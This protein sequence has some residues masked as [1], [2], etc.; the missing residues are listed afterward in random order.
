MREAV[1]GAVGAA[2]EES[3]E[4]DIALNCCK[5]HNRVLMCVVF[6]IFGG[7]AM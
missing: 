5:L 7:E 1:G 6:G 3:V 2:V 4:S